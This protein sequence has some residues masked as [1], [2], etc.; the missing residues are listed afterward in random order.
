MVTQKLI[1]SQRK[2][3]ARGI[4]LPDFKLHHKATVIK[5]YGIGLKT[6]IKDVME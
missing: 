6:D 1:N 5:R 2:M 4:T 3:K